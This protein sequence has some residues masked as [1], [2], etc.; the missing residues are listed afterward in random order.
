M[1]T[2]KNLT[3]TSPEQEVDD[4]IDRL[5]EERRPDQSND[6][7][8][9]EF[10]ALIREIKNQRPI[11]GPSEKFTLEL[12]QKLQRRSSTQ[13]SFLPWSALVASFL[14]VIFLLSPW[15]H[16][17]NDIVLA[18]EQ[19]VQQLQN[20]HG[21]LEKVSINEAGERQIFQ[22]TD[23]WFKGNN[24][25]TRTEDSIISVNNG[26]RRWRVNPKNKE[27]FLLPLYLD[28]HNFDLQKE[29]TIAQQYPHKIV[30]QDSIAGRTTIR[31]EIDPPGG[32][33]YYLWIDTETHLP[34]QLQTAMQKAIQTTYT[35]KNLETN[36]QI[37]DNVFTYNLPEGYRIVDQTTDKSM[38][39][40]TEAI[41][42]S[43]L[44]PLQLSEKPQQ[45]FASTQR[46]VFDFEDTIVIETKA[47]KPFAPSSLAALGQAAGG[48]LEVLP[49]TLRWQQNGLELK[50][51]GQRAEELAKQIANTIKMPDSQVLPNQPTVKV[52]V[53]MEIVKRNQQQV[54]AGSSPWQLD[55]VQVAFTFAITQI[56]PGGI[57]GNPSIN[58][59]SLDITSNNGTEAVIQ[60][61]EGPIKTVYVKRLVRHAQSGI[62]AAI[63][64]DPK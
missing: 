52:E 46:I 33:P 58:F 17:N 21:T 47:L 38:S 25:A 9:A 6:Q 41:A 12:S 49:D 60:F 55:P 54:D 24:Y 18:M 53:D 4:F 8:I 2:N 39:G 7:D 64:Y 31:I 10:Q 19:T 43:G 61:S 51:Q 34:V 36:T 37:P 20:Y 5:N 11:D 30:G 28:P 50:V 32:L 26:E 35:F 15:S 63:G 13:K 22:Q 56:S 16:T 42:V 62:W 23:V 14:I 29:A 44:T 1:K 45:I 48:P 3:Q 57:T 40:L 59:N 27:L